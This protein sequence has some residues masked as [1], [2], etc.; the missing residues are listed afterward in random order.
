[1]VELENKLN[2]LEETE[3]LRSEMVQKTNLIIIQLEEREQQVRK[4]Y[5][6]LQ[7]RTQRRHDD[8]EKVL[9]KIADEHNQSPS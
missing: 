2:H 3:Q 9:F 7:R 4:K 6:Y 1:M 8:G 5:S